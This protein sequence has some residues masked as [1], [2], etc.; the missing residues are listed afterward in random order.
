MTPATAEERDLLEA[1]AAALA[2]VHRLGVLLPAEASLAV[3]ARRMAKELDVALSGALGLRVRHGYDPAA[4]LARAAEA[5]AEYDR[6]AAEAS[7]S[8]AWTHAPGGNGNGHAGGDVQHGPAA[9]SA[10]G[11]TDR[12][13]IEALLRRWPGTGAATLSRVLNI[14][15]SR[16]RRH[17][18]ELLA[19][20][21]AA[22]AAHVARGEPVEADSAR[23]GAGEPSESG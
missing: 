11:A 14:P 6:R 3:L 8:R 15:E 22:L 2:G 7:T 20:A 5:I 21:A 13:R 1:A 17:K 12:A 10:E 9:A 23:G 4:V 16:C 19:D 18:R